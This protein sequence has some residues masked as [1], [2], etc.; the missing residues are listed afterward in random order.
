VKYELVPFQQRGLTPAAADSGCA[1]S[2]QARL[3]SKG[4]SIQASLAS[5]AAAAK[6]FR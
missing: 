4:A 1:A 6:P 2:L 5:S 3:A